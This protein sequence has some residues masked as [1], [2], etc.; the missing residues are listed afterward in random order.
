MDVLRRLKSEPVGMLPLVYANTK[1]DH[2]VQE[3]DRLSHL[4]I[5]GVGAP[6]PDELH[7]YFH[8]YEEAQAFLQRVEVARASGA[9]VK[10]DG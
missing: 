5:F 1:A 2:S 7:Q 10:R 8:N 9:G 6:V 3:D 4:S